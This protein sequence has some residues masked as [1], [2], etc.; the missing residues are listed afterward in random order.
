MPPSQTRYLRAGQFARVLPAI[1]LAILIGWWAVSPLQDKQTRTSPNVPKP[2]ASHLRHAPLTQLIASTADKD[3]RVR[4]QAY[5]AL[6]ESAGFGPIPLRDTPIDER[7]AILLNWLDQHDP[8]LASDPC[9]LF[10]QTENLRFGRV[11]MQRCMTCHVREEAE[12]YPDSNRC[13][14]CHQTIHQQWSSSAHANSLSHLHLITV[15][16]ITRQQKPYDFGPLKGL[17]CT[18]CHQPVA[19]TAFDEPARLNTGPGDT[20]CITSFHTVNCAACHRQADAQWKSWLKTPTYRKADWPPGALER[21]DGIKADCVGCHMQ[22]GEHR[23][24]ARRDIGLL[25]DGLAA[26]LMRDAEVL[27]VLELR[28]LAGHHFP[29]GTIRRALAVYLQPDEKPEQMIALL[30]DQIPGQQD[31]TVTGPTLSPGEV[32]HIPLPETA[33]YVRVRLEYIRNRFEPD[34]YRA[35]IFEMEHRF[36]RY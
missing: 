36:D 33:G 14:S 13:S 20:R 6:A 34:G 16:P 28:N 22:E 24:A 8:E 27:P 7:E 12:Q 29:T 32:R 23:W 26:R 9:E 5:E 17:S 31:P 15:D 2:S 11:L 1:V 35:T 4:A 3:W 19:G 30:A 18:A 25:Q 21:L 10:I